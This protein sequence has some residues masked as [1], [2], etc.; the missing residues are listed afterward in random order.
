M[1]HPLP[2][3][4]VRVEQVL[5]DEEAGGVAHGAL[6]HQTK[7]PHG[8]GTSRAKDTRSPPDSGI[9]CSVQGPGSSLHGHWRPQS[10]DRWGLHLMEVPSTVRLLES[11]HQESTHRVREDQGRPG[12]RFLGE[13][14]S[15][16]EENFT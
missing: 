5:W 8:T 11:T 12:Q 10:Q 4:S 14:T 1:F 7:N 16:A 9:Y 13:T 2:S 6:G 15:L 3:E